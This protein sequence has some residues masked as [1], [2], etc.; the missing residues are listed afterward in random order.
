MDTKIIYQ[1]KCLFCGKTHEVELDLEDVCKYEEGALAQEAFPSPK[2]PIA[3][4]EFIISGICPTC[5]ETLFGEE[6]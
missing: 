3:T 4:M 1:S 6:Q 5:Q 2:Y